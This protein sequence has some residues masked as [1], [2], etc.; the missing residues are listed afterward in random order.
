MHLPWTM[1][2]GHSEPLSMR[3]TQLA[4]RNPNATFHKTI[5]RMIMHNEKTESNTQRDTKLLLQKLELLASAK[6]KS[7]AQPQRKSPLPKPV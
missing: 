3:G 2:S 6:D 7:A 4:D 1:A 5:R